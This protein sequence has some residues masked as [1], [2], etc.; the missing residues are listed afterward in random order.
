MFLDIFDP[1]KLQKI[2]LIK[3]KI[4]PYYGHMFIKLYLA[5]DDK[6]LIEKRTTS[7]T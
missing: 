5:K 7:K 1:L 4:L 2:L 6:I 3:Y